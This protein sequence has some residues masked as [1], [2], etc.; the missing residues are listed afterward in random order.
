[1]FHPYSPKDINHSPTLGCSIWCFILNTFSVNSGTLLMQ[2]DMEFT[3][4]ELDII[5][6]YLEIYILHC[7]TLLRHLAFFHLH[8]LHH[9]DPT[10]LLYLTPKFMPVQLSKANL[11]CQTGWD[12]GISLSWSKQKLGQQD[13]RW[14]KKCTAFMFTEW[15]QQIEYWETAVMLYCIKFPLQQAAPDWPVWAPENVIF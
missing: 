11:R 13:L 4:E 15:S 8:I 6:I 10:P 14:L 9:L 3:T 7:S 12:A 1:M 2:S 5:L